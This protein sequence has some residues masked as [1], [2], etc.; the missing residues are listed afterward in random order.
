LGFTLLPTRLKEAGYATHFFGKWHLGAS[1][2]RFIPTA[3]GFDTSLGFFNAKEHHFTKLIDKT[4]CGDTNQIHDLFRDGNP[5][6]LE[7]SI[8]ADVLYSTEA[9]SII[10]KHVLAYGTTSTPLF[11]YIAPN[12]PHNPTEAEQ[13]FLDL[14]PNITDPL[15]QKFYAMLSA[16][17]EGVK[18]VVEA[19]QTTGLWE[20]T[21]FVWASDNGSPVAFVAGASAEAC[22]LERSVPRHKSVQL[23]RWCSQPCIC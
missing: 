21:L 3:R 7:Y 10:N 15:Q 8:P 23:G 20:N 9:V 13:R 17:D 2:P 1:D 5:A 19:L 6:V 4:P 22:G 11:L 16:H 14:Y 12:T 18:N